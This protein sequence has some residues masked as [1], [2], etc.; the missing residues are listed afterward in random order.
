LLILSEVRT[1]LST[2]YMPKSRRQI[3]ELTTLTGEWWSE[4]I[5]TSLSDLKMYFLMRT[6][7]Q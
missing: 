3:R 1:K 5:R 7:S 4:L 6:A 2:N